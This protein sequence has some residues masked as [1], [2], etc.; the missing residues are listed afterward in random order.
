[1]IASNVNRMV[2]ALV[3]VSDSLEIETTY[4]ERIR[5]L[6]SFRLR[7]IELVISLVKLNKPQ[8]LSA[9]SGSEIFSKITTLVVAY[10]WNNFLQLKVIH[11]FED[12][13]GNSDHREFRTEVLTSSKIGEL[14]MNLA[15]VSNY[16]HIDSQRPIRHGYMATVVKIANALQKV[17]DE[18]DITQ[19]LETLGEDD[20]SFF[21]DGELKR[22][23]EKN[24]R[25][26]GSQTRNHND[27]E[28]NDTY[29]VNMDRL[30]N[31]MNQWGNS[32]NNNNDDEEEEEDVEHDENDGEN[33]D[34]QHE[35]N[36]NQQH[37][38]EE[39]SA[40]IL[41]ELRVIKADI[42]E[43]YL[44]VEEFNE[45]TFWKVDSTDNIDDLLAD[46]E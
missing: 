13:I 30:M 38:K 10:P 41:D 18:D 20:W 23:N 17:R 7:L 1:M 31:N 5:P 9:L 4:S 6:G 32:I 36:H 8:I 14:L 42:K 28:E 27:D 43:Q 24:A 15:K 3:P 29:E 37:K 40:Y 34:Y 46:Y 25:I 33:R 22:S 45:G 2:V 12:I 44:L 16:T 39:K 26:I 11:L 21:V 19:Y 35:E